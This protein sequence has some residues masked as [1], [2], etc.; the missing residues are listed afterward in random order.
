MLASR[1]SGTNQRVTSSQGTRD[2]QKRAL[3][4]ELVERHGEN[5][6]EVIIGDDRPSTT[7][8]ARNESLGERVKREPWAA[9]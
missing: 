3:P 7:G 2:L 5:C 9:H 6:F 8:G 4:G 1:S